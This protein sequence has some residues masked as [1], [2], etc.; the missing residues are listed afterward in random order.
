MIYFEILTQIT[1]AKGFLCPWVSIQIEGVITSAFVDRCDVAPLQLVGCVLNGDESFVSIF[2]LNLI[3]IPAR[4]K[5]KH[6]NACVD[7]S[8]SIEQRM[9]SPAFY[10]RPQTERERLLYINQVTARQTPVLLLKDTT[11]GEPQP[12][13]DRKQSNTLCA[14]Y[15][16]HQDDANNK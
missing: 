13:N 15:N 5:P 9:K 8:P 4:M 7:V 10:L 1:S 2:K 16:Y 12:Q 11:H 14:D 6:Y 3:E